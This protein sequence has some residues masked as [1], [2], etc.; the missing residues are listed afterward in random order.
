MIL[1]SASLG[2]TSAFS[3]AVSMDWSTDGK[4]L[5]LSV[6]TGPDPD[7]PWRDLRIVDLGYSRSSGSE[8]VGNAS[9][10]GGNPGSSFGLASSEHSPTWDPG[11]TG[12]A[13]ER[14]VFSQSSDA[15]RSMYLLDLKSG[16]GCNN[17]LRQVAARNPRALDWRAK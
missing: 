12:N 8:T 15:G 13:C 5:A 4:R 10:R 16:A 14:L 2:G 6:I 9:V 11:T 17:L 7:Y 3:P 1:D